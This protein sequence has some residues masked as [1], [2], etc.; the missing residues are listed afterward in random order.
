VED[1]QRQINDLEKRLKD[2][3]SR[4]APRWVYPTD[5]AW[6]GTAGE[7]ITSTDW[8]GDS[9][10]TTAATTIDLSAVFS[11]VPAS[12][13]A[14]LLRVTI[15][16]SGSAANDCVINLKPVGTTAAGLAVRCSGLANDAYTNGCLVVPCDANG[17]IAYS[18][19]ASG[20]GTMDVTLQIWAYEI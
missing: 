2:M 12:V 9:Y 14:I 8:D 6:G 10:S 1:L 16:D 3:E 20:A 19:T 17:D 4:G 11:G 15:R 18:I 5:T 13:H 7:P